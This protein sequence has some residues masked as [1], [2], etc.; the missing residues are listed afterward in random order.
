MELRRPSGAVHIGAPVTPDASVQP[1]S[2]FAVWIEAARP[3]TLPA[4]VIPVLVGSAL[5]WRAG[6]FQVMPASLCLVFALLVQIGTN[7]AN[8]YS[9]YLKGAD[10]EDRVGPRRAVASGWIAARTMARATALTFAAAF[11]VGCS[12]MVWGGWVLLPIGIVSLMFG[13][14]YTAGPYPLAYNGLGDVFVFVFFGLVAVGGTEY[15]MTRGVDWATWLAATPVGLLATNILVVNNYRDM[16]TDARA[17]KRTTVVRFGR[18]FARAQYTVSFAVAYG[19]PVV[20]ALA[21]R[22]P[23]LALPLLS[24]P[25]ALPLVRALSL[26]SGGAALNGVLARTARAL[27]AFGVLWAG[28]L[29]FL[30]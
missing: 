19:L 11:C 14:A 2:L 22:R 1:S 17:G 9:D 30:G 15:V 5:A 3:K 4:A 18:G 6:A 27:L 29:A 21:W 13:W 24:L 28:A 7:F 12:L 26:S 10:R 8:D 16:E 25:L 23:W 20:L